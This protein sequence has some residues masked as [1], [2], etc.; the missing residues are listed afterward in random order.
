MKNLIVYRIITYILLFIAAFMS[1]GVF[2]SLL[3]ALANPVALLPIF[4]LAC[5]IIY[6]YCSWRLLVRGIDKGIPLK[7]VVRDLI[8]INGI[9]SL[10]LGAIILI[11]MLMV[12]VKP[13][14][15]QDI[16]KQA[17]DAQPPGSD[18]NDTMLLSWTRFM[19]KFLLVYGA[20]LV[21]HPLL[22]LR[23]V[24]RFRDLFQEPA[25]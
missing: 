12:L 16:M 24:K 6:T 7:P 19:V 14:L 18:W 23:L 22:T 2:S 17:K 8:R 3:A 21:V 1:V 9:I 25:N 4:L 20:M 10:V 13:A 11:Q 15:L 5:V